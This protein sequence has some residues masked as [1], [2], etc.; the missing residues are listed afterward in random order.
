MFQ[1]ARIKL[2]AWYLLIIMMISLSFSTVIYRLA[3]NEV[4]RFARFQ[5][6]KIERQITEENPFLQELRKQNVMVQFPASDP[7]LMKEIRHRLLFI[8]IY[9]NAAIVVLAGGL[10]YILAGKTLKPIQDMLDEQNRFITDASHELRTPLTAL[11]SSLEVHARDKNLSLRNAKTVIKN[12]IDEVNTLQALSDK[13]L[14]LAQYQ[15]GH[16]IPMDYVSISDILTKS[17]QKIQPLAKQKTIVIKI[18]KETS[19]LRVKAH[20]DELI[21]LFVILLDNAVKYSPKRS[22]VAIQ[23]EKTDGSVKISVQDEGIGIKE[24]DLPHIF[25]RF[26]RA[27]TSRRKQNANGYGLGLSIAKRIV[28]QH[29]GTITVESAPSKGSIFTVQLPIK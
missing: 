26:Y 3:T 13:L 20:M 28:E 2:T 10:G 14:V 22:I 7:E 27:D 23:S 19:P 16:T 18:K 1:N 12:S 25:D 9:I 21:D 6:A 5:R 15:N 17:I 11:K 8:L 4:E 24:N 29:H